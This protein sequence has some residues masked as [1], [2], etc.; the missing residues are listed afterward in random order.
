MK[1]SIFLPTFN[2]HNSL[3]QT[4]RSLDSQKHEDYEVWIV[5]RG[6]EPPVSDLINDFNNPRF[7]YVASSQ[8]N[9]LS[10]DAE[11]MIDS[12]KH[13]IFL[14]LADDDV[15]LPDTLNT[16]S[17]LAYEFKDIEY[18]S[19][20]YGVF[21]YGNSKLMLPR[22]FSGCLY[23]YPARS[24]CYGYLC[25]WGIGVKRKYP[26][27]PQSH[28]S[29]IFMKHSLIKKTRINQRELFIK[30][31]GDIG[32]VGA[33]ANTESF[34]YLDLPLG[35]IGSGHIRETDGISDR[36]KHEQELVYIEHVPNKKVACF[37]NIG[38][39]GHLKVLFRNSLQIEFPAYLRPQ[40]HSKQLSK[41]LSD[42]PITLRTLR[43]VAVVSSSWLFSVIKYLPIRFKK[44]TKVKFESKI[45]KTSQYKSISAGCWGQFD[46]T[47][48]AAVAIQSQ[49]SVEEDCNQ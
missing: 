4:L 27:P 5:D 22:D 38:L 15:I 13:G 8:S 2:R 23:S 30:S 17:Q 3:F 45:I 16:I 40:A 26:L 19:S 11:R 1:F 32:Y 29:L 34:L 18:F 39:D 41:V 9:H 46:S 7:K 10:D 47:Y 44:R 28:S 37:E 12:I 49:I 6:S 42:R 43:D 36:F 35:I 20:G 21:N 31:F 14:F 33:L 24:V 25:C 48:T